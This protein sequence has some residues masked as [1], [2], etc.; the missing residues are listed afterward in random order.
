MIQRFL[1]TPPDN[2][3]GEPLVQ[4]LARMALALG[5]TKRRA[6]ALCELDIHIIATSIAEHLVHRH[7]GMP[8]RDTLALALLELAQDLAQHKPQRRAAA[9]PTPDF[10]E[11]SFVAHWDQTKR[12]EWPQWSF[13][14]EAKA[15]AFPPVAVFV[16]HRVIR[17]WLALDRPDQSW[18]LAAQSTGYA[19]PW[20]R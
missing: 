7:L 5:M 6:A 20:K 14:S 2:I 12:N 4:V 16:L 11:E 3:K 19:D 13:V 18:I 10:V 15:Q 9:A 8:H 1:G 17:A